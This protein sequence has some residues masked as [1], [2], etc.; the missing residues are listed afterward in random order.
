MKTRSRVADAAREL[1]RDA[2]WQNLP[3]D[4][5][6]FETFIDGGVDIAEPEPDL[7][8]DESDT[9]TE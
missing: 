6:G 1:I 9:E 3:L 8:S 2:G 4:G 7:S 5:G